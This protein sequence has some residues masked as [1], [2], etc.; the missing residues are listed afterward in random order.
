MPK[1]VNKSFSPLWYDRSRFIL[2]KGGA[3]SGKSFDAHRRAVYRAVAEPGHNYAVVRKIA[4]TNNISTLPLMRQCISDWGLWP[5]F[6]ENKSEKTITCKLNGNQI[7]FLGLDD[8]EKIKSITFEHGPLTDILVEEATEIT[9]RDFN[10]LNLRLR[11]IARVPFQ[12]TMLFNP[13]S[14][15]HW[16]KRRLFDNPGE[17]KG[18]ISIH[19]STYLDNRFLDK[20]YKDELEALKYEDRVYYD[21]YALGKWGSVGNL[22]FRN[23]VF[24]ECPYKPEDFDAIVAGQDFGFNHYNAIELVGIKDGQKYSF[25]ELYLRHMTNDEII[26]ENE[27]QGV[28]SHRQR[29]MAD[30]AEPKSIK[31]W[32][33]AGYNMAGARK[34]PNSVKDQISMLNRGAWHIDPAACPG[35]ASEVSSYKWKEDKDGNPLDEPV[36]FKDDAIAACRYAMEDL[37]KPSG[38]VVLVP[39]QGL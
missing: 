14:D 29:C 11:G 8:I 28:L 4:A 23:A 24:E 39:M 37:G 3:G 35:L 36:A 17:K 15:S 38:G 6:S 19:E 21:V 12:I 9:E 16:I 33:Q 7:K 22:V 32:Q 1:W 20:G 18:S 26:A 30:S 25:K 10:Q 27:K 34:G 2:C 13:I 31:D 5:V